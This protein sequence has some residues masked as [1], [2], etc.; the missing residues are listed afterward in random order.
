MYFDLLTG[1]LTSKSNGFRFLLKVLNSD[2]TSSNE[3]SSSEIVKS[4]IAA[5]FDND[6]MIIQ[7]NSTYIRHVFKNYRSYLN[8]SE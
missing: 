8:L 1:V 4:I 7:S 5:D 2:G 3:E 6:N